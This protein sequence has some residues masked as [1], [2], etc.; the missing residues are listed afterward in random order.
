[1][2]LGEWLQSH[3]LHIHFL[4]M[5]D[6]YGFD[7][8]LQMASSH[9]DLL[10]RGIQLQ[11]AGNSLMR[12]LGGRSVH[13]VNLQVGG[14]SALPEQVAWDKA[15]LQVNEAMLAVTELLKWSSELTLPDFSHDFI[16]VSLKGDTEY[17]INQGKIVASNGLNITPD[18][19]QMH[20]K[21]HQVGHST[22]LYS[23]LEGYDYLVGPLARMNHNFAVLPKNIQNMA[24]RLG[25]IFPSQNMFR[26]IQARALECVWALSLAQEMLQQECP[27]GDANVPY[28]IRAGTC[29]F[30]T[31]APRGLIFHRYQIDDDGKIENCTIVPP[32]SQN[33][34]R[35]EQDLRYSI[36]QFGLDKSDTELKQFCEQ[37]IRNYDPCISCSTHFLDF[38]MQRQ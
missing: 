18:E 36:I 14:F 27:K 24:T 34:A 3:S 8:A 15:R 38:T 13:P 33:Q 10:K 22:A 30:S 2:N 4:A 6:Y 20:F 21:E 25:V 11:E 32:T 28:S 23:L 7:S 19:Y 5:P 35:I 31:E 1:M 37:L 17:P 26:S 29:S 16:S 9:S 12:L